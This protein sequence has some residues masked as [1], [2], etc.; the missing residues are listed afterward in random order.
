MYI[1]CAPVNHFLVLK[2]DRILQIILCTGAFSKS[3]INDA[4]T[5]ISVVC[6]ERII[7]RWSLKYTFI[8]Y[9]NAEIVYEKKK[10]GYCYI[11]Y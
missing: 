2:V 1:K 6:D 4:K 3:V 8:Y 10:N 5:N 9:K 7:L 11:K